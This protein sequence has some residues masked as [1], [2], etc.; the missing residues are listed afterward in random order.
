MNGEENPVLDGYPMKFDPETFEIIRPNDPRYDTAPTF[1]FG[2]LEFEYTK[3][4][5]ND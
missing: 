4:T 2:T 5:N 3:D 1:N